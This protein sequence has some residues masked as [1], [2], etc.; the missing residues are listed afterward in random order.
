M[1]IALVSD[2]FHPRVGGIEHH[3]LDLAR[4]LRA[5]RHDVVVLT[6]TP[7]VADVDGVRV[8]RIAGRRAP[9]FDF[10][11]S[12][13]GI[14]ALGAALEQEGPDAVHCHVSIVSPAA[15]GGAAIAQ[16]TGVPAVVSFHSVV[17][18][19]RTL[20]FAAG[21]LLGARRWT[22]RYTAVSERVARDVQGFAGDAPVTILPNGIDARFW[23]VD[24]P[25]P[26]RT[27]RRL[28]LVSV[29]RLNAKK[30]PFA[31]IDVV[32]RAQ[33]GLP[34]GRSLRLRIIGD[35]P[36]AGRLAD[37]VRRAG[38][39]RVIQLLG[40]RTREE[41]RQIYGE[42]DV[43]VLPTVRESFGIA[44]L[45]AC[46][47]GVPVIAMSASGVADVIRHGHQGL[48]A[49]SDEELAMHVVTLAR[50]A[51]KRDAIAA[52]NRTTASPYDWSRVVGLHLDAYREAIALRENVRAE[53]Y[54]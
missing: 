45:E 47:A 37:A 48:L 17:P 30:R 8:R 1:K 15:M 6:P 28:E 3:L 19:M 39:S 21:A 18:Q 7:G 36:L 12:P 4:R 16:R 14:R 13:D 9:V 52:N 24:D 50:N 25:P 53:M 44:A 20:A 5:A 23:R 34:I 33:V 35:G 49:R 43:F 54:A 26:P 11:Y 31:L 46:C 22:A 10:L 29:M 38:L 42:C 41:I 27:C 51:E 32:R 2:W 40:Y